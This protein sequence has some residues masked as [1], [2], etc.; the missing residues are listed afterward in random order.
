MSKR[1]Y[2]SD[3]E[4]AARGTLRSDSNE[5][6]RLEQ[7]VERKIL[8]FPILSEI[9]LPTMP[10][11]EVGRK[12]YFELCEILHKT[13]RLVTFTRDQAEAVAAL[14]Q[15]MHMR[16]ANGKEINAST[17]NQLRTAMDD[18]GVNES[19]KSAVSGKGTEAKKNTFASNGF[20]AR[21]APR[22]R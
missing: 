14:W 16:L 3:E 22:Q 20:A 6:V 12:K 9:P 7:Y 4:R 8:P 21:L 18:L 17:M 19:N 10:L 13:G 11:N 15:S 1:R 5:V 2:L